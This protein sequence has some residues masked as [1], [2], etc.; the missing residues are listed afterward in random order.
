[1]DGQPQSPVPLSIVGG[2]DEAQ[3]R[4][5]TLSAGQH[6]ITAAYSGDANFS[7]SSGSVPTQTVS[8]PKSQPTTT[9]LA[10]SLN[11][12]TV[13]QP[14]TFTAV[15]TA[16]GSQGSPK[17][18]VVFA[19]DGLAQ[20]TVPLSVVGGKD[21]A[22]FSSATLSAG[23][24]SITAAYSGDAT[25]SPSSGSVS[26]QVVNAPKLQPTTT[27]LTCSLNP[28]T[29]G[30]QVT[31][32]ALVSPGAFAGVPTGT[33]TLTIDGVPRTPVP[34]QLVNGHEQAVFAISTLSAGKHTVDAIYNGDATFAPSP[35]SNIVTQTVDTAVV[36]PP[37]VVSVQSFGAVDGEPTD[38]VVTFSTALDPT[39]AQDIRNYV[40]VGQCGRTFAIDS[41]T[42]DPVAHTVSLRP[43]KH[44]YLHHAFR[45][46]I[47]GT[48]PGGVTNLRGT[49]LDGTGDGTPGSNAVRILTWKNVVG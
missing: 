31:F 25:F 9:S 38:F 6:S 39:R 44:L 43:Y 23:Q 12:S 27:T 11:P 47:N 19:I 18:S 24:H 22:Q 28:S 15:V 46:T 5:A 32:I 26:T 45:L 4:S 17:G 40:I 3:F 35:A 42:Y 13:G 16:P 7:P 36:D 8:A 33:V 37:Q 14:V 41:A 1:M 30:Q 29:E 48:G 10:S 34:L 20:S 2:K 49:L 21:E